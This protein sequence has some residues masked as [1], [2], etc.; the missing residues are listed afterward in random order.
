MPKRIGKIKA[1]LILIFLTT[2]NFSFGQKF[3]FTNFFI[4]HKGSLDSGWTYSGSVFWKH[5]YTS[6]PWR[7]IGI[8]ASAAYEINRILFVS[9]G[10]LVQYTFDKEIVN[11][12]EIRPWVATKL[13]SQFT[14]WI[15]FEQM[16]QVEWR[17][18]LY[19]S[20]QNDSYVR[21]NY[22]IAINLRPQRSKLKNWGIQTG[23]NWFYLK[24]PAFGERY[25]DSREFRI[26]INRYF[27]KSKISVGY[28]RE[29]FRSIQSRPPTLANTLEASFSF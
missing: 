10:T 1:L 18:F 17:N 19:K 12:T 9:G 26:L 13:V 25:S 8:N 22:D 27:S 20:H 15:N 21:T 11:S 5:S 6:H 16:Y 24:E 7:R 3:N 14:N 29:K 23:Y 2:S 28:K 4:E